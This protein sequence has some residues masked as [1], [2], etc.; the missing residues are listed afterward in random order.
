VSFYIH[1]TRQDIEANLKGSFDSSYLKEINDKYYNGFQAGALRANTLYV[2]L[3]FNPFKTKIDR[4]SF[5]K[6]NKK[7]KQRELNIY[8][9]KMEEYSSRLE[10]N[11]KAFKASKLSVYEEDNKSYSSQLEF[12]NYLVGGKMTKTRAL[13]APLNEYLIGS[14]K[15]IQF[16][17]NTVQ[18]NYNDDSKQFARAIEIKD[19]SSETYIGILNT[20]MYLNI[21]YTITQSFCPLPKH[22]AKDTLKKQYQQLLSAEDDSTTQLDQFDIALDELTNSEICF[23]DYHF[24]LIV[25]GDSLIEVK[26][27]T[28]SLLNELS[29]LGFGMTLAD[30]A[31]PSTYFSQFPTNYSFRTRKSPI[32]SKNY[33]SLVSLHNFPKGRKN[34]NCWGEAIT[35]LKTANKQP[36]YF[37][38]HQFGSSNDFGEFTLGHFTALGQSGG[39]KTALINFLCNQMLKYNDP[40]TFP[41]NIDDKKKQMTLIY[42]DK[43]K[44]ALG[45]ILSAGG[46]YISLENGS[47]TGFNPFMCE[48][49]SSNIRNLNILMKILVTRNGEILT[50]SDEKKLSNA[51]D[52]VMNHFEREER[53]YGI[54]L[55]LENI[56]PDYKDE[57]SLKSRLELWKKGNKFGW[58]F[59]NQKDLLDFPDHIS[60]FGIDG[61]EFL[62][63]PDVS[64]SM[65]Y[66]ILWRCRDLKDGRRFGL[67]VDE[68][69]K[70]F[71]NQ[72][73]QIE[74]KNDLKTDRKKNAFIGMGSQSI[75]DVLELSIA[76]D[77]I[78]QSATNIYFY[79]DKAQKD[80]YVKGLNCTDEE[81]NEITKFVKEDYK[82]LI[83]RTDES[84]IASLDLSSIGKANLSILSTGEAY[85]NDVYRVFNQ[86]NLTLEEKVKELQEFYRG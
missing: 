10:S 30:I 9:K 36:Y 63:D 25:Y 46:R 40:K 44:G 48:N 81:F 53:E 76:K 11:L 54:S 6:I 66:Y 15:N 72:L 12:Y 62:D 2:T 50:S 26:D 64:G 78:E 27:N 71:A 84:V 17:G 16:N 74:V 5:V 41:S 39:G 47:S 49:T 67:M 24:T 28:N 13:N 83:K 37:N 61:T 21:N 43:D 19:Y 22:E 69:W 8:L 18:L 82:C 59:D 68:F 33:S 3:I 51:I 58:V 85:V 79:N 35:I 57:N 52:S 45:N 73:V 38:I 77:I 7:E 70:W 80:D 32:S 29:D 42:L 86:D 34:N 55:L 65:S 1:N 56:T 14:L 31:L 75:G 4:S 60:L 23:G 20:L